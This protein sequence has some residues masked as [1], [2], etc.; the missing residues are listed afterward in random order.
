MLDTA[1]R[2]VPA[3][4]RVTLIEARRSTAPVLFVTVATTGTVLLFVHPDQW[5]G[6]WQSFAGYLRLTLILVI[7]LCAALAT[8]Q[9]GRERRRATRDLLAA[10]SRPGWH[11]LLT[12]WTAL[13]VAATAGLSVTFAVGSAFVAPHATYSGG[14]WW[15]LALGCLPPVA[16][17]VALGLAVGRWVPLR[18]AG[19]PVAA[20]LYVVQA[21]PGYLTD[22]PVQ[23]LDPMIDWM[24]ADVRLAPGTHALQAL[25]FI[26][27]S[28]A[29]LGTAALRSVPVTGRTAPAT[30]V[31]GLV[32]A[33]AGAVPLLLGTGD[34]RLL[35]DRAAQRR[36]CAPG[37]PPVCVSAVD[38]YLLDDMAPAARRVLDR[39]SG[40]PGAPTRAVG[41]PPNGEQPADA[42]VLFGL[43]PSLWGGLDDPRRWG[44]PLVTDPRPDPGTRPEPDA[45]PELG[46]GNPP[47]GTTHTTDPHTERIRTG[48]AALRE[49]T[50]EQQRAW[51]SRV[52]TTRNR[53]DSQTQTG[54][55]AELG[56]G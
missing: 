32:L 43:Y 53:C 46:S 6:R 51:I 9:G 54:L 16:A 12:T 25:W 56:R 28:V 2:R 19:L 14:G 17:A 26:G 40:I 45:R 50:S 36:I 18:V 10:T 38:A 49:L 55:L 5:V 11:A 42:L 48:L 24:P 44:D 29:L 1:T 3:A 7:P 41:P 33:C 13:V 39:L 27:L 21:V 47:S 30:T 20:L 34:G 8:W 15:W 35:P 52:Y 22:S 37:D 23:G 4:T 31:A